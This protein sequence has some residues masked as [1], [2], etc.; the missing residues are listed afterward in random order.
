MESSVLKIWPLSLVEP[1]EN[2]SQ[3]P[4]CQEM[5]NNSLLVMHIGIDTISD[6]SKGIGVNPMAYGLLSKMEY[7]EIVNPACQENQTKSISPYINVQSIKTYDGGTKIDLNQSMEVDNMETCNTTADG[8]GS[9]T[10][11]TNVKEGFEH[12]TMRE[13][14]INMKSSHDDISLWF[15]LN[16]TVH[17]AMSETDISYPYFEAVSNADYSTAEGKNGVLGS[18]SER[19]VRNRNPEMPELNIDI[20]TSYFQNMKSSSIQGKCLNPEV[21]L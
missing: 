4:F 7:C 16:V 8:L 12:S 11:I 14:P 2:V 17:R 20:K 15:D 9:N 3:L 6:I 13:C 19:M 21:F 10:F 1:P 5:E 18:V